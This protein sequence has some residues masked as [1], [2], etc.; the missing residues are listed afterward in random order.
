[1]MSA[2]MNEVP[3]RTLLKREKSLPARYRHEALPANQ[4]PPNTRK[5]QPNPTRKTKNESDTWKLTDE[6]SQQ[7]ERDRYLD[8]KEC[9]PDVEK[10]I[11][12]QRAVKLALDKELN[13]NRDDALRI[14]LAKNIIPERQ[15]KR[16]KEMDR[17]DFIQKLQLEYNK[18]N[19]KLQMEWMKRGFRADKA[20]IQRDKEFR[21]E[22]VA[23]MSE[24]VEEEGERE[25]QDVEG[26]GNK[27]EEDEELFP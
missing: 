18:V 22:A 23:G 25:E 26:G 11:L 4:T 3:T 1:M 5:R 13:N 8:L 24:E 16:L 20:D 12:Q 15:A 19:R 2:L 7:I 6:E 21:N 17:N 14:I 9:H 27:G 10:Y